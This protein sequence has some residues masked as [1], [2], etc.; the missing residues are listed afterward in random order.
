MTE[1]EYT[2][3]GL[4][5]EARIRLRRL[6]YKAEDHWMTLAIWLDDLQK[7][8]C[9]LFGH[10]RIPDQCGIPSHDYCPWCSKRAWK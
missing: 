10:D 6:E 8:I 9:R 1:R 3:G 5:G 2:R 4:V 7:P